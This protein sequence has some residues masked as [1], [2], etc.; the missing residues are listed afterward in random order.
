MPIPYSQ[1]FQPPEVLVDA[2]TVV[3]DVKEDW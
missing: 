1:V 3:P 2:F